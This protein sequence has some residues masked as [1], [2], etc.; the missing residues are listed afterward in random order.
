MWLS[1]VRIHPDQQWSSGP[2]SKAHAF[3]EKDCQSCHQAKFV[4]VRDEACLTCHT[5]NQSPADALKLNASLAQRGSP[6]IPRLISDH[7]DRYDAGREGRNG[8]LNF[9]AFLIGKLR[10]WPQ[11]AARQ[12]YGRNVMSDRVA[13]SRAIDVIAASEQRA[14]TEAELAGRGVT[15]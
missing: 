7:A 11:D 2:L 3:L 15:P 5:A 13:L 4:S 1:H 12:A 9:L 10:T 8:T 6:F 14:P